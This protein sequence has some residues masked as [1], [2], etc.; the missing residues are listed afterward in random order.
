MFSP[1]AG[2]EYVCPGSA[3]GS[4]GRGAGGGCH[5]LGDA[6][7]GDLCWVCV[8]LPIEGRV[9]S[10][11]TPE[12]QLPLPP[13]PW[14]GRHDILKGG[15]PRSGRCTLTWGSPRLG[16]CN[17]HSSCSGPQQLLPRLKAKQSSLTLTT[18]R[19]ENIS[20]ARMN[21]ERGKSST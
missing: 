17:S 3:E 19:S 15:R 1:R 13:V 14:S 11:L 18:A 12:H 6:Q 10:Q 2:L 16:Y 4:A 8:V 7:S 9:H 5:S 21:I 20:L